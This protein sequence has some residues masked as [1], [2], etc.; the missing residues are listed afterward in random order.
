NAEIAGARASAD[1]AKT[2][3]ELAKKNPL[4]DFVVSAGPMFGVGIG[5]MN[6]TFGA[7]AGVTLP[8]FAAKKQRNQI[9]EAEARVTAESVAIEEASVAPTV[10]SGTTAVPRAPM[11]SVP[12]GAMQ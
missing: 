4:P 3:V 12:S 1:A 9:A 11:S 7:G 5:S 2:R 8:I 10:M 6:K